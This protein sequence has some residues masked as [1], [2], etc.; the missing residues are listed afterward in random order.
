MASDDVTATHRPGARG[1][2]QLVYNRLLRPH[3]PRRLAV[4]NGVVTRRQRLLDAQ[5]T[6]P[7][8][9]HDLLAALETHVCLPDDVVIVGG[10]FGVSTVVAAQHAHTVTTYEPSNTHVELVR[11]AARLN[12]VADH[13]T[14]DHAAVGPL[15]HPYGT[16]D[17]ADHLDG[18]D[19]PPCD[20]L[21]LDCEGAEI[22]ILVAL[23]VTPRTIVVES[24]PEFGTPP[25]DVQHALEYQDYTVT[26]RYDD[27]PRDTP[28]LV[29]HQEGSR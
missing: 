28:V 12:G 22:A 20:V 17:G 25:D 26:E 21:E 7:D 15:Q 19:I 14:V 16:T 11:E 3:L 27:G 23:D 10:G 4:C 13:V 9:E 24:H 18:H 5:D 29:A 1:L 2:V 6:F 8:Y